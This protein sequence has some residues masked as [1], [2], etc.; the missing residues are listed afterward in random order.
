METWFTFNGVGILLTT[1]RHLHE[2]QNW[3]A[4][5]PDVILSVYEGEVR[6]LRSKPNMVL[7]TK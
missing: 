5:E 7:L 4:W 1:G 2:I 6:V 3:P